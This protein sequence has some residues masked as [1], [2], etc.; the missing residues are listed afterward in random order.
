M[1]SAQFSGNETP[2]QQ[3]VKNVLLNSSSQLRLFGFNNPCLSNPRSC[4][5]DIEI[6]MQISLVEA[7]GN[8]FL[9]TTSDYNTSALGFSLFVKDQEIVA[10]VRTETRVWRASG[11]V[12]GVVN[13]LGL[14]QVKWA[15]DEKLKLTIGSDSFYGELVL[16]K[17]VGRVDETPSTVIKVGGWLD[18]SIIHVSVIL[19]EMDESEKIKTVYSGT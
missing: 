7:T 2:L 10:I 4:L 9:F 13:N 12:Q 19:N 6:S 17:H 11:P 15:Y 3:P 8:G 14:I 5:R 18:F 1:L 16:A